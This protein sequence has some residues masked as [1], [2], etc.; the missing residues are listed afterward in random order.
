LIS[1]PEF[2]IQSDSYETFRDALLFDREDN[3]I[4]KGF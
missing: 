1:N 4:N 3:P 2:S